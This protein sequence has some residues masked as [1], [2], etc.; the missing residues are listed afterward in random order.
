MPFG[1]RGSCNACMDVANSPTTTEE[2]KRLV[3]YMPMAYRLATRLA[4]LKRF[5]DFDDL[6]Q[7]GAFAVVESHRRFDQ[8]RGVKF[9]TY[10][11]YFVWGRLRQETMRNPGLI[12]LPMNLMDEYLQ[13]RA[14]AE[15]L[16]SASRLASRALNYGFFA[17]DKDGRRAE[18]HLPERQAAESSPLFTEVETSMLNEAIKRLPFRDQF[19]VK[20]RYGIGGWQEKTLGELGDELKISK[21]RVS[22][23][24]ARAVAEVRANLLSMQSEFQWTGPKGP[25]PHGEVKQCSN[26]R[27]LLPIARFQTCSQGKGKVT[28]RPKCRECMTQY[29]RERTER[30]KA[31]RSATPQ[32]AQ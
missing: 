2:F 8:D 18:R 27:R 23:I 30:Q 7:I 12:R 26:C 4:Y 6:L 29:W 15:E 20:H 14:S 1:R 31:T 32:P 19:I 16:S 10:A 25:I 11:M 5:G 24:E 13:E 17:D 9:L 22:Q 3:Q 21:Q 28:V